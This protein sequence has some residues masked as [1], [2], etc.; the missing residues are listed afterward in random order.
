MNTSDLPVR[1]EGDDERRIHGPDA[2]DDERD[3]HHPGR[4][5][6]AAAVRSPEDPAADA[7]GGLGAQRVQEGI[8]GGSERLARRSASSSAAAEPELEARMTI[9]QH[10]D[11]LRT[12]LLRSIWALLIA[13]TVA[14]IFYRDLI[15]VATIPHI[16]AMS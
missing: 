8:A 15:D 11:E 12:R 5:G 1:P 14:M 4:A 9:V 16:R 3:A 6:G 2:G 7:L 13:V 10:L